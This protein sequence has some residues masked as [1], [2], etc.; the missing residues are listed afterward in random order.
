MK[1]VDLTG[2]V[3]GRLTVIKRAANMIDPSKPS[4]RTA[5]ECQCECGSQKNIHS[6]SLIT[7]N[8]MSCG[9]YQKEQISKSK[10]LN[11]MGQ[12]FGKL[13]VLDR[14]VS[15]KNKV[16]WQCVCD[17]GKKISVIA[18]AL[19]F[20]N[21]KSCGCSRRKL[22]PHEAQRRMAYRIFR[23]NAKRRNIKLE[24]S[25]EEWELLVKQPCYYCGA[26][27]SNEYKPSNRRYG[28]SFK[29]N[30]IDRKDPKF[31]YTSM[32][33]VSCCKWCNDCKGCLH[34]LQFLELVYK[35]TNHQQQAVQCA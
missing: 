26:D 31:G 24:I 8:T 29:C 19:S 11:I 18:G 10:T 3:F 17:C 7:G 9:C 15:K 20:G 4:G 32:N 13:T 16:W 5:W 1:I 30:G 35:I 6:S 27:Q 2:K 12:K 21:T 23:W 28:I 33:S 22:E 14:D 34:E 25:E